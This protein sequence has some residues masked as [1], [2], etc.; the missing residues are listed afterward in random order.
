[1]YATGRTPLTENLGLENLGIKVDSK[2]AIEVDEN[3]RTNINTVLAI[4]DVTDRVN[5]TPVA[6]A[7]AMTV[8]SYLF[9][10]GNKRVDYDLIPSAVFSLPNLATVG[11]TEEEAR[12]KHKEIKIFISE[13]KPLKH[14]L[15]RNHERTLMKLVV[16]NESDLVVGAHMVGAEAGESLQGIAVAMKAGATKAMFDETIGIHPTSAE[17]WVTMRQ[18]VK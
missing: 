16:D 11:L 8:V 13:F 10:D 5:L 2:N 17:E 14:T 4:G 18:P 1:M 7:E 6:L 15:T 3:Y 9:G 12:K